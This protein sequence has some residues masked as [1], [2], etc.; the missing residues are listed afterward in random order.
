MRDIASKL[1]IKLKNKRSL[2]GIVKAVEEEG[3]QVD[4]DSWYDS[5]GNQNISV[6][7]P[8]LTGEI[9]IQNFKSKGNRLSD[10]RVRV[11]EKVQIKASGIPTLEED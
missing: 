2:D 7:I 5:N 3:F 10:I 8:F 1:Q 9:V 6:H 4:K 11:F